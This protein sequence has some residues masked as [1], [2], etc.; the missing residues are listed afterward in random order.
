[1][2]RNYIIVIIILFISSVCVLGIRQARGNI[3]S[4]IDL[5]KIPL[6]IGDW[7]GEDLEIKDDIY[8][9]LE[10]ED[11][12]IRRYTGSADNSIFFKNAARTVIIIG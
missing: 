2:R 7:R 8:K 3:V 12:I 11:I 4:K 6:E 10:T 5:S 1:M 9:A